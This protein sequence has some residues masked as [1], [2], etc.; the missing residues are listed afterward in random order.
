[1]LSSCQVDLINPS[2][3][4]LFINMYIFRRVPFKHK[5]FDVCLLKIIFRKHTKMSTWTFKYIFSHI[6]ENLTG[7]VLK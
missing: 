4:Q 1:M 2:V 3:L 6:R 7:I 5:H